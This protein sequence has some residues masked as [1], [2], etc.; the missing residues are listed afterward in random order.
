MNFFKDKNILITGASQGLGA[1]VAKEFSKFNSKLILVSRS[2]NKLKKIVGNCKNSS[3]H[4]YFVCDFQSSNEIHNMTSYVKK[5]FK[6]IDII[7]HI[8]GGGLGVGEILPKSEDYLKVFNLNLF[9]IFEI[10][11]EL[12]P[13]MQKKKSGTIFHVGS[14]ASNQAVGSISYNVSKFALSAYV[15]TLGRKLAIDKICVTGIN[16][17]GFEYKDNAMHRLKN[18]NL[19]A[20]K[21]FIDKRIPLQRMPKANELLPIIKTIIGE[22]NMMLTGN[23]ISCDASEGSFYT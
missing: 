6:K 19:K 18:N 23:M 8:A 3:H 4:N 16:P 21:N 22:N 10:N 5:K 14:I 9:S 12:V 7:M 1:L 2:E 20:Y 17:G 11:R 15:R 13:I